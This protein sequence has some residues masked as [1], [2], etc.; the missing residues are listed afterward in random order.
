M[1]IIAFPNPNMNLTK[2]TILISK[3]E[4]LNKSF[5]RA[6]K[7]IAKAGVVKYTGKFG[8]KFTVVILILES[9]NVDTWLWGTF[10]KKANNPLI[11]INMEDKKSFLNRNPVFS[12]YSDEH[13]YFQIPFDLNEFINTVINLKPIHDDVTR[14]LIVNDYSKGYEYKLITHDLKIVEG[15]KKATIENFLKV[16]DFYDSI[17]EKK[18]IK[19]IDEKIK[20]MENMDEWEQVAVEAKEYLESR[21][22]AKRSK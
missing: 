12:V 17:G 19:L 16:R 7:A 15:D 1:I 20:I 10:R 14:K 22:K 21:L 2:K 5:N 11:I 6:M 13:A 9:N 18:I 4:E 3:S 8:N